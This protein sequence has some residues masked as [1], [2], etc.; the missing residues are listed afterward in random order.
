MHDSTALAPDRAVRLTGLDGADR[1][2]PAPVTGD[3]ARLRQV[4][5]NLLGNALRHTP[6]GSPVELRRGTARRPRRAAGRRPRHRCAAGVVAEK[7]FERFYRADA[8]RT[9]SSGGS[10]L[11]LA[12]VDAIVRAHGGDAAVRP[13]PGGGA[14]FEVV[15]PAA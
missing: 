8:S 5:T 15:L 11:G 1:P 7:I 9:R 4:V 6:A 12:I 14:T 2:S 3:E 10:G 13:T